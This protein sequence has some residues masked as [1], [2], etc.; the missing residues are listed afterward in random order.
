MSWRV[1]CDSFLINDNSKN[2]H[3]TIILLISVLRCVINLAGQLQWQTFRLS[4]K[5]VA[6]RVTL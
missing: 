5:W 6:E 2:N 3:I 4:M 1:I